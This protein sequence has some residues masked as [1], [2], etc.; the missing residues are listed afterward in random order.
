[1]AGSI[2]EMYYKLPNLVIG[3]HGCSNNTFKKVIFEQKNLV[4]SENTYDWLGHGIYF[5]ENNYERALQWA[6]VKF[7]ND[8]KVIGAVIDLGNCFNLADFHSSN[9]LKAGYNSFKKYCEKLDVPLPVNSKKN[10]NND[11]LLRDLDCAVI[12]FIHK[13]R[14]IN[15]YEPFDSVRGIFTE[16]VEVYPGSA[17]VEKTHTQLCIVNQNC[18]KGYFVPRKE[19]SL[20][21]HI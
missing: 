15:Q 3:F 8:A 16:G 11:V 19:D 2:V 10:N 7:Q 13:M 18:I 1:M 9:I 20:Y 5:W 21:R 4:K 17:F 12:Q 14:E 6:K